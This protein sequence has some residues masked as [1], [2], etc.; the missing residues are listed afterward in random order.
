MD[1]IDLVRNPL[2]S[3]AKRKRGNW[4][5]FGETENMRKSQQ[6]LVG[7]HQRPQSPLVRRKSRGGLE[8]SR[9]V[10]QQMYLNRYIHVLTGPIPVKVQK[11]MTPFELALAVLVRMAKDGLR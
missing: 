11:M 6:D 8:P 4:Q 10:R 9:D 5:G 1:K 7:S 3:L 2:I